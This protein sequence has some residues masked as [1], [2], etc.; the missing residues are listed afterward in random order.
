MEKNDELIKKI[1]Q[2][3]TSIKANFVHRLEKA[4]LK[5]LQDQIEQKDFNEK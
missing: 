4:I 3:E 1:E 5:T 2:I